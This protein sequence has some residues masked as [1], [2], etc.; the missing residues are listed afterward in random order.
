MKLH[1]PK[2]LLVAVVAATSFAQA[3]DYTTD[4]NGNKLY[5]VGQHSGNNAPSG[6]KYMWVSNENLTLSNSDKLGIIQNGA[7]YTG[8]M[9]GQVL[10]QWNMSGFLNTEKD[11]KSTGL[12]TKNVK[13]NG[14]LTIE[15]TAQLV[16]GGQHKTSGL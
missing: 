1:L 3:V 16:L 8:A 7:L 15:D 4:S 13:I 9:T 14:T 2:L 5:N 6:N 10:E 11:S 12:V